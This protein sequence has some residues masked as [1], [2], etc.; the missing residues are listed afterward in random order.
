MDA[1]LVGLSACEQRRLLGAGEVS[2]RELLAAHVERIDAVN[3]AVNAIV[4]FDPSVGAARAAAVDDAVAAGEP[5]GPLA[6]LVTAHKDLTETA[7]FPTAYGSPLLAGFRPSADSL[8]VE[9]MTAAGAVAVGKT[10]TPEFGAGSHTFNPVYGVTR[11]PYDLARSAGGSSGGAAAALAC[12]MVA[13]ADGSDMGG[14]LRNPAAWNAV[15]GFRPTPRVVPTVLSANPWSPLG[16][17]GPMGRTVADVALLLSVI[18]RPDARDPL[19][20]AIDLPER[21]APPDR[22]LAGRLV[23]RSRRAA[24]RSRPARRPRRLPARSSRASDGRSTTPSP[25]CGVPTSAS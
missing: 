8:L 24:G 17:E 18:G 10:N 6:G 4:A 22:P 14:S 19:A 21:L 2:A 16:V 23:E 11:N 20:L 13:V 25:T 1:D 3:G 9:R 5:V 12:G 7:D 15:V